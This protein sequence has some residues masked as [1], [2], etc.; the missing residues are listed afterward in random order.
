MMLYVC[1]F[2]V[3]IGTHKSFSGD[4]YGKKKK[5]GKERRKKQKPDQLRKRIS[6]Q[7][8]GELQFPLLSNRRVGLLCNGHAPRR[9]VRN[10]RLCRWQDPIS[11]TTLTHPAGR[12]DI[13]DALVSFVP[14]WSYSPV[15]NIIQASHSITF[16]FNSYLRFIS[17]GFWWELRRVLGAS[18]APSP[19]FL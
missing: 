7:L 17:T 5:E 18:F 2:W 15:I 8:K 11:H 1:V 10:S 14:G 19:P 3:G 4:G 13:Y 12:Q 16:L 9:A 6:N